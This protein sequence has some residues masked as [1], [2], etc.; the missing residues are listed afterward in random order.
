MRDSMVDLALK[1]LLYDKTRFGITVAGVA[2]AVTLVLVQV[3]L[4]LGLLDNASVTI[5]HMPADIWVTPRNTPNI[6]FAH[7]FAETNVYRVRSI[8][9]VERADNL[10]VAFIQ[11]NLPSGARETALCYAMEDFRHWNYPWNVIEGHLSQL[12]EGPY[13]MMDESARRRFGPF[14][15]GD[16]REML[17]QRFKI[18][19]KTR[20]A[21]SF[22]TTP[23]CFLDTKWVQDIVPEQRNKASY[24]V[25][26]LAPGADAQAVKAE[27]R[28]RLPFNDVYTK[29]EWSRQS[30][31]YWIASTGLGLN[32]TVTIFLGMLVGIVV[33]A[34]TLY[35][36]TMEHL[37]EYG[38]VKAIGGSNWDIYRILF[39]Q[40]GISAIV[41]FVVALFPSFGMGPVMASLDLK[42]IIPPTL[43]GVVFVATVTFCLASAAVS[44]RKVAGIDPAIVF[45]G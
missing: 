11:M 39:R 31:A 21:R 13:L 24:I 43:L 18:V 27:I 42:L 34:Q 44:F 17:G 26:R 4:F 36:S 22:T 30:R 10:T 14:E 29:D 45:R 1:T 38:T 16:Y 9:G 2:F 8:P 35:A 6:D 3:G 41:G 5:D 40:A 37:K 19:G 12:T 25:A 20:G 32:I 28:R 33:V 7:T 15:T 23:V